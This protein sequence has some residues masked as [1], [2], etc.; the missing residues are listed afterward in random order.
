MARTTVAKV[1]LVIDTDT[2]IPDA[3]IDQH[4]TTA[5]VITNNLLDQDTA[6]LLNSSTLTEI[7][8]YLAAHFYALRDLQYQQKKTGDASATFQGKTD[9]GFNA[10]LWGQQAMALDITNNLNSSRAQLVWLG[11]TATEAEDYWDRN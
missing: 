10:T 3:T 11:T 1:R 4:I 9:M 7:E 5:N 2:D 6:N 8:T